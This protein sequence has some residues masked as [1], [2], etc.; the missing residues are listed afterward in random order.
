MNV[1]LY[2]RLQGGFLVHTVHMLVFKLTSL[3]D[4]CE[5]IHNEKQSGEFC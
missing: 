3:L 4:Y 5:G 2:N 1:N